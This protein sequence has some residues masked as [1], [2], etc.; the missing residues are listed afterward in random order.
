MSK[1]ERECNHTGFESNVCE[2]CGYPDPSKMIAAL[3]Q[4]IENL[5]CCGNCSLYADLEC[6]NCK[7]YHGWP[8]ADSCCHAWTSDGKTM[9]ERK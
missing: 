4:Q 1:D 2:I 5:K 9:E 8:K 3:K 6:P 7:V